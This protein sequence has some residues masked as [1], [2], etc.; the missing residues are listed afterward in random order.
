MINKISTLL[1]ISLLSSEGKTQNIFNTNNS[2]NAQYELSNHGQLISSENIPDVT[3]IPTKY[4][5]VKIL[6]EKGGY[7]DINQV[8]VVNGHVE[9][10]KFKHE[11]TH[12]NAIL[13]INKKNHVFTI[14]FE[15][16]YGAFY[17][18]PV[19]AN[20]DKW[21]VQENLKQEACGLGAQS[22]NKID[23]QQKGVNSKIK[24]NNIKS[25]SNHDHISC[26]SAG[27]SSICEEQDSIGNLVLDIFIGYSNEAVSYLGGG[28][29]YE[30]HAATMVETV[31]QAMSNSNVDSFYMRLVGTAIKNHN[32][33]INLNSEGLDYIPSL[34]ENEIIASGADY[35]CMFQEYYN[36]KSYNTAG[37][38]ATVQGINSICMIEDKTVFRHEIGHNFGSNHCSGGSNGYPFANGYDNGE[39]K[40]IMCGNEIP[41]YSNPNISVNNKSIG[42]SFNDNARLIK[43][44]KSSI[45]RSSTHRIKFH[46]NDP[47]FLPGVIAV[48]FPK[49]IPPLSGDRIERVQL[50][51][52]DNS[53]TDAICKN[54]IGYSD[55]RSISTSHLPGE[56]IN[57]TV[58]NGWNWANSQSHMWIDWNGDGIFQNTEK[59]AH[60]SGNQIFTGTITIPDSTS[61]GSK[62]I[63]IRR[64]FAN[65]PFYP[66]PIK[67]QGFSG[68]ET[69]DYTLIVYTKVNKKED[70]TQS[71]KFEIYPNPINSELNLLGDYPTIKNAQLYNAIG[72]S[73]KTID[74]EPHKPIDV[75][76]LK[77]GIYVLR[78]TSTDLTTSIKFIKD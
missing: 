77:T 40:T 9:D 29:L 30:N 71:S 10:Q 57:Y 66:H 37:G 74:I 41:Y 26:S 24:S 56:T 44:R 73:I 58:T 32:T 43:E 36:S 48:D 27:G 19:S 33:G 12:R 49:H 2:D 8:Y 69:E 68:G 13:A 64:E 61:T 62:V 59:I 76:F 52:I 42:T 78:F 25:R 17:V 51:N 14:F 65:N 60:I 28:I 11:S 53:S 54:V 47:C 45:A 3:E 23:K 31:N 50:G 46:Q 75:S 7:T 72:Q 63:R 70:H 5:D 1:F 15:N 39:G 4:G 18:S 38:W 35:V 16:Q 22:N 6:W 20:S 21:K 34:F 55:Y 67:S